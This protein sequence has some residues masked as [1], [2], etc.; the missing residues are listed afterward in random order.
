MQQLFPNGISFVGILAP[1][2]KTSAVSVWFPAGSRFDP[3][4]KEG[5]AHLFE[6]LLMRRTKRFA[7][8]WQRHLSLEEMGIA[9]NAFTSYE[10]AFFHHVQRPEMTVASLSLLLENLQY[11]QIED[12]D[13]KEERAAVEQEEAS[14]RSPDD[15]WR[16]SNAAL[17][18]GTPMARDFFGSKQIWEAISLQDAKE[19]FERHYS[20]AGATVVVAA[21]EEK[22]LKEAEEFVGSAHT[23]GSRTKQALEPLPAITPIPRMTIYQKG[24]WQSTAAIAFALPA[25]AHR[26]FSEL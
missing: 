17:W 16:P 22:I 13:L 6:H 12:A 26:K 24:L 23:A 25:D 21:P 7:N 11:S 5:L 4:G 20:L 3:P 1:W 9:A 19:F 18:P 15:I 2:L 14:K 8:V 10:T